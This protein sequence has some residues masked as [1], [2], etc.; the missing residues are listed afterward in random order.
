M[1]FL[2]SSSHLFFGLPSGLLNIGFHL[3][4]FLPFF[5]LAF[6]VNGQTNLIFVLL[7][8]CN[9]CKPGGTYSY[10]CSDSPISKS[11]CLK[12]YTFLIFKI[13]FIMSFHVFHYF[14]N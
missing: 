2:M 4:T 13:H 14:A 6:D 7:C 1:S 5:L 12:I 11:K 8:N 10:H 3:H 9:L